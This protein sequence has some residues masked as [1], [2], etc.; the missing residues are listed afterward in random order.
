MSF[1]TGGHGHGRGGQQALGR[2]QHKRA[3]VPHSEPRPGGFEEEAP[4]PLHCSTA[5]PYIDTHP[6]AS[7]LGDSGSRNRALTHLGH[8]RKSLAPG[9]EEVLR[10]CASAHLLGPYPQDVLEP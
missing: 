4:R 2:F 5:T 8:V 7:A 3:V 9:A 1:V 10:V 6:W